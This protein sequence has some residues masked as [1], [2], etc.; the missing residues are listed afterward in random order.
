MLIHIANDIFLESYM[1]EKQIIYSVLISMLS[2]SSI[3]NLSQDTLGYHE[4]TPCSPVSWDRN[5]IVLF[6][7]RSVNGFE[8]G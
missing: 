7:S 4:S 6:V 2:G 3:T 1:Y 5:N 8:A